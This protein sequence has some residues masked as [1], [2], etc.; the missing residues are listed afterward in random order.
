M[1]IV[2]ISTENQFFTDWM[3]ER[4]VSLRPDILMAAIADFLFLQLSRGMVFVVHG[5]TAGTGHIIGIVKT[6]LPVLNISFMTTNT[7]CIALFCRNIGIFTEYNQT[8]NIDF[9]GHVEVV[10]AG[11]MANFAAILTGTRCSQIGLLPVL[12]FWQI[13]QVL[14]VTLHAD[15][16]AEVDGF[17]YGLFIGQCC[18]IV[19]NSSISSA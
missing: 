17:F 8:R 9:S 1:W 13:V 12:I 7:D 16:A 3:T 2:A 5:M 11:A 10:T 19:G 14:F 15:I 18:R 6:A 4:A